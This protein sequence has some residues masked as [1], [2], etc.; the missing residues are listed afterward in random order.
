MCRRSK[1]SGRFAVC[2]LRRAASERQEETESTCQTAPENFRVSPQ[3]WMAHTRHRLAAMHPC[4]S[5]HKQ[6]RSG[7]VPHVF[8]K[9]KIYFAAAPSPVPPAHPSSFA[10]SKEWAGDRKGDVYPERYC[11]RLMFLNGHRN[12]IFSD[13]EMEKIST[14]FQGRGGRIKISASGRPRRIWSWMLSLSIRM[15]SI[16]NVAILARWR[17]D[18]R[19]IRITGTSFAVGCLYPVKVRSDWG[20]IFTC[21]S[22]VA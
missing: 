6:Q 7:S 16:N 19:F 18:H 12:A 20:R 4:T 1:R 5:Q 8:M 3:H 22:R 2:T 10:S 17:S 13:F 21:D 9:C 14:K 11:K 15:A